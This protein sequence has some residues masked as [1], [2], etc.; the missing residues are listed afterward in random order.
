MNGTVLVTE[1]G[2]V[3]SGPHAG[4]TAIYQI[5]PP[6]P[7]LLACLGEDASHLSGTEV[8]TFL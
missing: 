3:T 2:T 7:D 8:P 5:V 6:Q 4:R 1:Q